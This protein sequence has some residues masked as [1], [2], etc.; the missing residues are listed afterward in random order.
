MG[1]CCALSLPTDTTGTEMFQSMDGYISV[2]L[3]SSFC[4]GIY[5]D[6][7][8]AKAGRLSS[9]IAGIKEVTP[10]S[11]STH[12]IIHMEMLASRKMVPAFTSV[13][14]DFVKINT[15]IK[16]HAL[17]S[18]LLSNYVRRWSTDAFSRTQK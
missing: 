12:C 18:H 15:N 11:Q 10:E 6:E 16:A 14:N 1:I 5:T 8:A 9:L 2:R 4:V 17:K 3:K 7:A 13:L